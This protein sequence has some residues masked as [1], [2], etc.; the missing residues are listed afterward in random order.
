MWTC[1]HDIN[2]IPRR[3]SVRLIRF[4]L[5]AAVGINLADGRKYRPSDHGFYRLSRREFVPFGRYPVDS[6][7]TFETNLL[8]SAIDVR[9]APRST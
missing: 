1:D 5:F 9:F 8:Q 4:G 3:L 7:I 6:L 2:A